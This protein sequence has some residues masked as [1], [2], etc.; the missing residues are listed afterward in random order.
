[1]MDRDFM[2]NLQAKLV[3]SIG[4]P[5]SL[6]DRNSSFQS[7][8][9]EWERLREAIKG[10]TVAFQRFALQ[11]NVLAFRK[12]VQKGEG[13]RY[14]GLTRKHRRKRIRIDRRH[15]RATEFL[16]AGRGFNKKVVFPKIDFTP[17]DDFVDSTRPAMLVC[18][19]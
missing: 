11:L 14:A 10:G 9:A 5:V 6:M 17:H 19:P 3:N 4:I 7:A 18:V 8:T 16:Y 15:G 2:A 13:M 12:Y 1:M